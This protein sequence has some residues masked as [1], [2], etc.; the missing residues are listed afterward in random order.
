MFAE[1]VFVVRG[2]TR[3]VWHN[4]QMADRSCHYVVEMQK[5]LA[6]TAKKRTEEDNKRLEDLEWEGGL[7]LNPEFRPVVPGQVIEGA[8]YEAGKTQRMGPTVRAS[9]HSP[10][11]WVIRHNGPKDLS[12]LRADP[13]F[14]FK[15]IIR[16]PST[17]AR[18]LRTRPAF[19]DW[20]LEYMVRY[21][22]DMIDRDKV[23]E[24]TRI[25]GYD[26]GLSEDRHKMGGRF[27]IATVDGVPY[28]DPGYVAA[29]KSKK[30][31]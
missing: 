12:D 20:S 19:T 30:A 7:Y 1:T 5:I 3:Q 24:L 6:K 11:D 15:C 28:A 29:R 8:Y 2:A 9:I 25:L 17:G 22:D 16:N 18:V 13:N 31:S 4:A 26:I 27:A 14:R 23:I 21:R 10:A